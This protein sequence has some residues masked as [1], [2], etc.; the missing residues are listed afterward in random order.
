[1]HKRPD[2]H[3]WLLL[4]SRL[5]WICWKLQI[6]ADR[7]KRMQI[8]WKQIQPEELPHHRRIWCLFSLNNKSKYKFSFSFCVPITPIT[9]NGGFIMVSSTASTV[10]DSPVLKDGM[11]LTPSDPKTAM[12]SKFRSK[13][14]LCTS[15]SMF[16]LTE[17]SII[18]TEWYCL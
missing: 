18:Q 6:K 13:L 11:I 5:Q 9:Q 10:N 2:R 17:M 1:M 7:E 14:K 16:G 12:K 15:A 3:S 8:A 4:R